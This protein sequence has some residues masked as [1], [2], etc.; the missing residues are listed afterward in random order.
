MERHRTWRR[1]GPAAQPRCFPQS[2]SEQNAQLFNSGSMYRLD[3]CQVLIMHLAPTMESAEIK[4]GVVLSLLRMGG[5][6]VKSHLATSA[7][8]TQW[9]QL[10]L[11]TQHKTKRVENS[12]LHS[13]EHSSLHQHWSTSLKVGLQF[14]LYACINSGEVKTTNLLHY[15]RSLFDFRW[16]SPP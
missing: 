16:F 1:D 4:R 8:A 5:K 15:N 12:F 2:H 6:Q 13:G 9:Q 10:L 3:T 14:Y 7:P 11:S